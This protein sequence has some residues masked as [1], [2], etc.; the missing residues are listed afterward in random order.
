MELAIGK[1]LDRVAAPADAW[2]KA[3]DGAKGRIFVGLSLDTCN[4]GFSVGPALSRRVADLGLR[5]DFDIYVE[6]R[7]D[8]VEADA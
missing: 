7:A 1:L 2:R 4:R 3:L 8:E 5:L 6:A